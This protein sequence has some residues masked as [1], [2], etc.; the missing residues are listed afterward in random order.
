M[1]LSAEKDREK[2]LFINGEDSSL[3][4]DK[5]EEGSQSIF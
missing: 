2:P 5:K 4:L 1:V 3:K